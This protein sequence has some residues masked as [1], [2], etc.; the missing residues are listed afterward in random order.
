V[1]RFVDLLNLFIGKIAEL[2]SGFDLP[3]GQER[4]IALVILYLLTTGL[5]AG[6]LFVLLVRRRQSRH[7][8]APPDMES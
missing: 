1:G 8:G 6:L 7:K 4:L 5:L 3:S 2:L